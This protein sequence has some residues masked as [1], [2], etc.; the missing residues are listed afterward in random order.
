MVNVSASYQSI[1][2][3]HNVWHSVTCMLEYIILITQMKKDVKC[4]FYLLMLYKHVFLIVVVSFQYIVCHNYWV[5]TSVNLIADNWHTQKH[6]FSYGITQGYHHRYSQFIWSLL[7]PCCSIFFYF[8]FI[9]ISIL[10]M[11]TI[12]LWVL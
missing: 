5:M 9:I 2:V 7:G 11:C 1:T 8:F 4:I 3:I 6:T 12:Y 10:Y